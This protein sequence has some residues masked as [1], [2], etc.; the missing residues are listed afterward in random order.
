MY[1]S[2]IRTYL[3]LPACLYLVRYIFLQDLYA[4]FYR[5]YAT[6]KMYYSSLK[7]KSYL[8]EAIQIFLGEYSLQLN[9]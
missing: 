3:N 1:V 2:I 9:I 4:F 7:L 5:K 8:K 6:L